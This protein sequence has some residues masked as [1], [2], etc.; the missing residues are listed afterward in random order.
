MTGISP[1]TERPAANA[2]GHSAPCWFLSHGAPTIALADDE[3]TRFWRTLGPAL[4]ECRAVLAVSAHWETM[5]PE[6]SAA[7]A[8]ATIH[9]FHGFPEALYRLTYPAAGAPDIAGRVAD[10]LAAASIPV[11]LVEDRGLDH[12]AWTPLLHIRPAAD[13]PV[14]QLSIQP[15]RGSDWH[16]ALGRALAPLRREGVAVIASGG[17]VH[18]VRDAIT[19]MQ[20]GDGSIPEWAASFERQLSI[21]VADGDQ[22]GIADL[23]LSPAGRMAH[24]R[25][26]HLLPLLV[27]M[28]AGGGKGTAIHSRFDCGSLAMTAYVFSGA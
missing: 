12:G 19:R 18:N 21:L 6:V 28:G 2:A 4:D 8:P 20:R 11:S 1:G 5:H 22:D 13:I 25:D 27:A 23:L 14:L 17:A 15:H 9:D 7:R 10:L 26:E 3:T 16:L 24:P